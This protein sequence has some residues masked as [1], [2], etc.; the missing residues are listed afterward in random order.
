[1]A[2]LH[3]ALVTAGTPRMTQS[4][5]LPPQGA[6]NL[7]DA[8]GEEGCPICRIALRN[9]QRLIESTNYD[10]LGDPGIRAE[11]TE[12]TGYCTVHAQQWLSTAFVLGTATLYR[13]VLTRTIRELRRLTAQRPFGGR[14][15]S[16]LGGSRGHADL[17]DA[18]AP[19]RP[20]PACEL[21][22]E[23]ESALIRTLVDRLRDE[24]MRSAYEASEGLCVPHLRRA[25][26]AS[27][28]PAVFTCLRDRA[29]RTEETLLGHLNEIVRKHDYRNRQEPSGEEKGAAARTVI[30]VA[31]AAG[32]N[33]DR[34]G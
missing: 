13:D 23:S 1:M 7:R 2:L 31:G 4:G 22:Q 15:I 27:R 9:V 6:F 3:G 16:A 11:L 24:D 28:D 10:A 5:R 14:L 8:F 29:I 30:H 21:L 32:T 26:G 19:R 20:C 25:L 17:A 12:A 34:S 33:R 18:G